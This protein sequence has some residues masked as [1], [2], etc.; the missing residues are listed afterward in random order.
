MD[1][2]WALVTYMGGTIQST[3]GGIHLILTQLQLYEWLDNER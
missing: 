3:G 1:T 2:L